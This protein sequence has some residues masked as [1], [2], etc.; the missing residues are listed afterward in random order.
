MI[1]FLK[2]LTNFNTFVK[3]EILIYVD[4][5]L[6]VLIPEV[7]VPV[8]YATRGSFRGYISSSLLFKPGQNVFQEP[9]LL[10]CETSH[11]KT[12]VHCTFSSKITDYRLQQKIQVIFFLQ[13][14]FQPKHFFGKQISTKIIDNKL[15]ILEKK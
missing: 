5:C 12:A 14:K 13:T 2:N 7:P 10:I 11:Q 3:P 6:F 9:Q 8:S 1:F 4:V 15:N